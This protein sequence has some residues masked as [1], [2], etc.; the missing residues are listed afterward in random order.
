MNLTCGT[1]LNDDPANLAMKNNNTFQLRES[2]A[3]LKPSYSNYK[4]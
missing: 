4:V 2:S 3:H 1:N